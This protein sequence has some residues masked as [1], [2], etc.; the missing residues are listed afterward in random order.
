MGLQ[1]FS[2]EKRI[3]YISYHYELNINTSVF[4]SFFLQKNFKAVYM[5]FIA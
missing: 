4:L 3:H 1:R 2:Q 5:L